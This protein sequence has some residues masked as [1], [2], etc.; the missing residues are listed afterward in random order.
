MKKLVL[1]ISLLAW[2]LVAPRGAHADAVGYVCSVS[3]NPAAGSSGSFGYLRVDLTAQ[4]GCQG[5]KGIYYVYSK[6]APNVDAR[7]LYSEPALMNLQLVLTQAL[8]H[9]V[10]VKALTVAGDSALVYSVVLS[11][12]PLD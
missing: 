11:A 7:A 5:S 2:L 3:Y 12:L 4:T 1:S 10:P 8:L 9:H 6:G